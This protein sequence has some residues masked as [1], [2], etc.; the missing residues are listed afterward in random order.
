MEVGVDGRVRG[1][2][3]LVG[4]LGVLAV[5]KERNLR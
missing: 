2:V 3:G 1:D 4:L 5:C